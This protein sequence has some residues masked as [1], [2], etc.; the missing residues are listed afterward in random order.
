MPI[1]VSEALDS[2]TAEIVTVRRTSGGGYVDGIY[3]KG[4]VSTFKT[5][6]SVQQPTP[7]E[8]QNLAEGERNKDI[9]KFIS[10]KPIRTASDRDE[11]IADIVVY[12]S[13]NYKIISVS[14]WDSHGHT[15]AFG[16]RDQ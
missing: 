9:R 6:C 14:D 10:K 13:F 15:T 11:L 5:V 16:A 7:D 12:K 2:D 8:L 3:I 1:N 4:S